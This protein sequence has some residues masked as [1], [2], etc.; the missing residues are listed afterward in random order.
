MPTDHG[1]RQA[2]FPTIRYRDARAAIA[3]LEDVL[4]M[5][6]DLVVDGDAGSVAHAQLDHGGDLVFVG[7]LEASGDAG[8][9]PGRTGAWIYLAVDEVEPHFARAVAR[10][11]V[12][13]EPMR[14]EDH[15]GRGYTVEDPEG[16]LWSVGAYRPGSE[17]RP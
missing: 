12:V 15:G 7:S 11:A 16:N 2:V 10:G 1:R 5:R 3:W 8:L 6:V 9:G 17:V 13:V 4:G 14:N